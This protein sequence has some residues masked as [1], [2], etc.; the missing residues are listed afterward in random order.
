MTLSFQSLDRDAEEVR[1]RL[2]GTRNLFSVSEL[3]HE[4]SK[5][6]A[7]A[8]GLALSPESLAVG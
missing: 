3:F 6:V 1:Q 5:I 4:N 8:P 7:A 2:T